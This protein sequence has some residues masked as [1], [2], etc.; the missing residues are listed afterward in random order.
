M[1]DNYLSIHP[2]LHIPLALIEQQAVRS[3]GA[4]GQNVNSVST[5]VQIKLNIHEAP[6]PDDMKQRLLAFSDQRINSQGV[7]TIKA[8]SFRHQ[9]LN[10]KDAL[11]RLRALLLSAAE[12]PKVRRP[13]K[14]SKASRA[15]RLDNKKRLGELKRLRQRPKF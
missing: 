7:I 12:A 2:D 1:N 8:Q 13:T 6:L 4:G 3:Q 15:K 14:P 5:A 10:R 9:H 11:D